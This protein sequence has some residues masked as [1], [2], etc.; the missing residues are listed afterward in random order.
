MTWESSII[1]RLRS[2]RGIRVCQQC[3]W[4]FVSEDVRNVRLC[5]RCKKDTREISRQTRVALDEGR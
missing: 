3:R 4:K 2:V 1:S 5:H